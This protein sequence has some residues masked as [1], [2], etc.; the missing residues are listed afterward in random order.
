MVAHVKKYYFKTSDQDWSGVYF[1]T[2]T[3]RT[4]RDIARYKADHDPKNHQNV[5]SAEEEALIIEE[6]DAVLYSNP[7]FMDITR[8]YP[9]ENTLVVSANF[10]TDGAAKTYVYKFD[11]PEANPNGNTV[12]VADVKNKIFD[13][14]RNSGQIPVYNFRVEL[15]FANNEIRNIRPELAK[16]LL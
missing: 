7:G 6:F 15:Q 11:S 10:E 16:K 3:N 5:I 13:E 2:N 1:N 8:E 14:K 9:D 12:V 4:P